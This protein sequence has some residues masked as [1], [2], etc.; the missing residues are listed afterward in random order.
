MLAG[1]VCGHYRHA[2]S[3][4]LFLQHDKGRYPEQ[5]SSHNLPLS[6]EVACGGH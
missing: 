3:V 5:Q 1:G 4:V 6:E 2:A